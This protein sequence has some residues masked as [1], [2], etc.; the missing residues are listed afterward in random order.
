MA[1]TAK[2]LPGTKATPTTPK[3]KK[4]KNLGVAGGNE[5]GFGGGGRQEFGL[6]G[7]QIVQ[8]SDNGDNHDDGDKVGR[9]RKIPHDSGEIHHKGAEGSGGDRGEVDSK[10]KN[11]CAPCQKQNTSEGA[12]AWDNNLFQSKLT[13]RRNSEQSVQQGMLRWCKKSNTAA[14]MTNGRGHDRER[15]PSTI[16]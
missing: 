3:E 2:T 13:E 7:D 10:N 16:Q 1:T 8:G 15:M 5:F 12:V 6:G 14:M 9:P 11:I 4:K